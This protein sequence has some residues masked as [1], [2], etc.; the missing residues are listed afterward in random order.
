MTSAPLCPGQRP[1]QGVEVRV[2]SSEE[3]QSNRL[4]SWFPGALPEGQDHDFECARPVSGRYVF[5]QMVGEQGALSVCEV[6]VFTSHGQCRVTGSGVQV[7]GSV[8]T[9]QGQWS[10]HRIS[11]HVTGS[12]VT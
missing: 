1:L 9:S 10:R 5:V 11:G 6:Q 3:V 8:V 4:C 7:M 2:G 12:V